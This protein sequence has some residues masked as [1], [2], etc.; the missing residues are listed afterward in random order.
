MDF[1]DCRAGY[2]FFQTIDSVWGELNGKNTL[3]R[4]CTIMRS[5]KVET[6]IVEELSKTCPEWG[7]FKQEEA[8]IITRLGGLVKRIEA[9]KLTFTRKHAPNKLVLTEL[10]KAARRGDDDPFLGYAIVVNITLKGGVWSY[11][12]ESVVREL[13]NWNDKGKWQPLPYHYLH[14]KKRFMGEVGSETYEIE[15]T[16]FRQQNSITNV[17]A[18][19]CTVMMLN[20]AS[21]PLGIVTAE[22]VNR[23]LGYDHVK[24][25]FRVDEGCI[26]YMEDLPA[27]PDIP[28][29]K[30]V[31]KHYGYE[32]DLL[33]FDEPDKQR[34]FRSF[35][36]G[37]VESRFPAMLTFGSYDGIPDKEIGHVV[38]VVGHTLNF[39]SWLPATSSYIAGN[40]SDKHHSPLGWVDDLII[41]DDNHGMQF[42]LPAHAFKPATNPDRNDNLTPREAMGIFPQSYNVKMLGNVAESV[43]ASIIRTMAKQ[44]KGTIF[45]GNYYTERFWIV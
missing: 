19:S 4:I 24:R 21:L 14:I 26:G 8:A 7:R 27:G 11:I 33:Q 18:H 17:C 10:A 36:Y 3:N 22:D 44:S 38:P 25:K 29:L 34:K 31:F 2:S 9:V 28:Q 1:N 32:P 42:S 41:H 20:N 30:G 5:M 37:F 12:F 15:G 40:W 39:N 6:L 16:Y 23:L 45:D 13:G 35:L 43:A